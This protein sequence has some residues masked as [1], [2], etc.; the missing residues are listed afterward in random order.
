M[1]LT[2][3]QLVYIVNLHP[4]L[5]SSTFFLLSRGVCLTHVGDTRVVLP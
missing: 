2:V 1:L 5:S 4:L 3:T